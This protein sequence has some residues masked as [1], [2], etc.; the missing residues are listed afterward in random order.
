MNRNL[1]KH[2]Y[3]V[4]LP[5]MVLLL[6]GCTNGGEDLRPDPDEGAASYMMFRIVAPK[7][8]ASKAVSRAIPDTDN[9]VYWGDDYLSETG[10]AFDN[11]LL[12]DE[13]NVFITS[14]DGTPIT[15]LRN[16]ICIE[17]T[18]DTDKTVFSFSGEIPQDD[19]EILRTNGRAKIHIAANCDSGISLTDGLSFSHAGQPSAT[20][21]AIPM[22]GVK[23]FDFTTLQ[24]GQN[25]AGDIWLLRAMAKVEIVTG[26]SGNEPNLI[27]ALTSASV[28]NV[29]MQ[30]YVLPQAWSTVSDTKTLSFENSLRALSS[31]AG[32]S[33]MT[34]ADDKTTDKIVFYLPDT[35]NPDG[36]ASITLN[37]ATS[38]KGNE[39]RTDV[40]KFG[41]YDN[42]TATGVHYDIVRN[43]LYRFEVY[44]NGN[45]DKLSIRYTVCPWQEHVVNP[46]TF[47]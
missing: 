2:L 17:T 34:P 10:T 24:P 39:S 12:R 16:L 29:N 25:D 30:G 31:V 18:V 8:V 6:A 5:A 13:F 27:T 28:A 7:T 14:D 21:S 33:G 1:Y 23:S 38:I 26:T 44:L 22:W 41:K 46:P 40:I 32:I 45:S 35:A 4:L 36:T 47:D 3:A 19:V 20:F 43:H 11:A 15:R 9:A 37:Y 42:G